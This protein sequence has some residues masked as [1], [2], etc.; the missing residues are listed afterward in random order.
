[1]EDNKGVSMQVLAPAR[2][3]VTVGKFVNP[4]RFAVSTGEVLGNVDS[5]RGC[6]TKFRTR[7]ADARKML[8]GYTGGLHR[9]VFYGD[10]VR[11]IEQMGRLMGFQVVRE[12]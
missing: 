12:C 5:D 8:E 3:T 11:S 4:Q 10:Y 9:V 2:G 7:V 1:M 6:R